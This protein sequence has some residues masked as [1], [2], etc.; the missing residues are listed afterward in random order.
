MSLSLNQTTCAGAYS[1]LF[2]TSHGFAI[3]LSFKLIISMFNRLCSRPSSR[4]DHSAPR[5]VS[6]LDTPRTRPS[7]SLEP[8][9]PILSHAVDQRTVDRDT[10]HT[11]QSQA[12]KT[13]KTPGR[14]TSSL[15]K[16]LV[17]HPSL[18]ALRSKKKK[19]V[20]VKEGQ[21]LTTDDRARTIDRRE[22]LPQNMRLSI[23]FGECHY[24]LNE[25]IMVTSR[26]RS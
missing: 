15:F 24:P 5:P 7:S 26:Q 12:L 19:R 25:T 6:F 22:S 23:D 3:I 11:E 2:K 18:A 13:P 10:V 20:L 4:L 16:S 8:Y 21:C 1:T 14:R 9:P 17:H